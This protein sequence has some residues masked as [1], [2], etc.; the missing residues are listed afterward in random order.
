[1]AR[2]TEQYFTTNVKPHK[3]LNPLAIWFWNTNITKSSIS[4]VNDRY[5]YEIFNIV[6][7]DRII[8]GYSTSLSRSK[9]KVFEH[10]Q[11]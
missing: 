1:M 7:G 5:K 3:Y 4:V 10:T 2:I 9:Q 11:S 8:M 6:T